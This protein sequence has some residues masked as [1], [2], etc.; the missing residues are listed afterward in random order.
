MYFEKV[1]KCIYC[2]SYNLSPEFVIEYTGV[3]VAKYVNF[4][5]KWDKHI[6]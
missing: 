4:Y 1:L 3:S 2:I 6:T 5:T